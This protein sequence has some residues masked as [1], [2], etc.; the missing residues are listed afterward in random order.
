MQ[1]QFT[2]QQQQQQ[3][4]QQMVQQTSQAG[5]ISSQIVTKNYNI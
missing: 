4:P 5:P 3:Q 1:Q 2:P